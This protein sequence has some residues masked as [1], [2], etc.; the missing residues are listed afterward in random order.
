MKRILIVD[1]HALVRKGIR[2]T[3]EDVLGDVFFGEAANGEDA[4]SLATAEKWDLVLLD[5][6]LGQNK[7][8]G[9]EVL[10]KMQ[11][12]Q[13]QLSVL[14]LSQYPESEFGLRAIRLGASGYLSK[15]T[16][17]EELISAIVRILDGHKYISSALAERLAVELSHGKPLPHERLSRRELELLICIARGKSLKEIAALWN[18]SVKTVGTYHLRTFAK[19]RMKSDVELTRYAIFNRLVDEKDSAI[20]PKP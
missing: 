8:S 11:Q 17:S 14:I 15:E 12:L 2:E 7:R 6:G 13:P 19:M 1:D 4:L 20:E 10:A 5:I 16:A 9:L 3:L 18:L